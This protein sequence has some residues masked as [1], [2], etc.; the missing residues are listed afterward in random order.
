[1]LKNENINA[2]IHD[3]IAIRLASANGDLDIVKSLLA[4][5]DVDPGANLN[6]ALI[7][8]AKFGHTEVVRLLLA[9]PKVK[10][11]ARN[12]LAV[13]MA[14]E[15]NH[16]DIVKLLVLDG[17]FIP[18]SISFIILERAAHF[19]NVD[20][21]RFLM[22]YPS[23]SDNIVLLLIG[24]DL[25]AIKTL[26]EAGYS[27]N[28]DT[29]NR[30]LRYARMNGNEEIA[31]Y[32]KYLKDKPKLPAQPL[33]AMTEQCAICLSD[34]NLFKGYMTSCNHQFHAECLQQWIAKHN[35]CPMCRSSIL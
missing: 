12:Y 10:S 28:E 8:A 5:S 9:H 4:R 31:K 3:N 14:S 35:T 24:D 26:V 19:E 21:V 25:L 16:A 29:L 17:R 32:F 6:E 27:L 13:F 34:E 11:S 2:A 20:L 30:A 33:V 22:G 1:M 23:F 18:A 7:S 15:L